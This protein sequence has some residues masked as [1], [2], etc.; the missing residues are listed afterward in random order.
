M[1][2]ETR[3]QAGPLR[4]LQTMESGLDVSEELWRAL[5]VISKG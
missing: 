3:A 4:I 5:R 1:R 2:R